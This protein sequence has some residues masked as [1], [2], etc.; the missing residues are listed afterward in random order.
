MGK[1]TIFTLALASL[2]ILA[3]LWHNSHLDESYVTITGGEVGER[4][5]GY[6]EN[7]A[8][9]AKPEIVKF[10]LVDPEC[11]P[12]DLLSIILYGYHIMLD[13]KGHAPDYCGNTIS[14]N[15]CHFNAGNSLGGRNRGISLVGV[16]EIYPRF[17]KRDNK[18]ISLAD[19]LDNCFRRSMNGK[20]L[21]RD[22]LEM[23][24]IIAYLTW[25]SHEAGH[26]SK[27]PWLGLKFLT[28][29]HVPNEENGEKVY[30]HNCA[31]CHGDHG[32]G[33]GEPGPEGVP[34]LWGN[35]SFNDGAGMNMVPMMASFVYY[36]MP[37][38]QPTLTEE[39][40]LDVSL[41]I[42]K[43]SRPHFTP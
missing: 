22:S 12:S 8:G 27:Y 29:E 36:N 40:A 10:D 41:Y 18:D 13:T 9:K 15:N 31:I 28:S 24:A 1:T 20:A 38:G 21:P 19:R 16:T 17:S 5:Y 42:T 33:T 39:E 7:T 2:L 3:W 35:D 11:A 32:Q 23:D 37:Y 26:A 25:I 6:K 14:C 43:Q 4:Y 34:P 30:N